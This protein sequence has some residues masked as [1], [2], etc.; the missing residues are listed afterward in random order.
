MPQWILNDPAIFDEEIEKVFAH[1]WQLLGHE[2]ELKEPGSY[3]TRWLVHDPILVVRTKKR[4]NQ[5]IS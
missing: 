1:A 4:R 3:I 5:S 2:S